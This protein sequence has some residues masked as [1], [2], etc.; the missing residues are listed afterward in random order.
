MSLLGQDIVQK[1]IGGKQYTLKLL[2]TSQAIEA[3]SE[4]A[5]LFAMPIGSSR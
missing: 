4:L 1:E 3:A 2:T 5:Q